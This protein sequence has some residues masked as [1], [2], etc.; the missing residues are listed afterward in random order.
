MNQ[1][2]ITLQQ[3]LVSPEV[4]GDRRV[5]FR[6]RAPQATAVKVT[7]VAGQ[8]PV[9][10]QRDSAGI[11]Q[12]TTAP[13]PPQRYSYLFE[14]D[15]AAQIDPYNRQVKKWLSLESMFEVPGE[16]PGDYEQTS[17]PHGVIH[18][19][20]YWSQAAGCERGVCVYTPPD[21]DLNRSPGYPT[22]YLLHGYG[23]DQ[24]TWTE[25]GRAH[26]VAD[27]LLACNQIESTVMVMPYGHPLPLELHT[28]FDHYTARN[29]MLMEQDL[30]QELMPLVRANYRTDADRGRQAIAGLSMG[31]WQALSIGLEHREQFA[32]IGGFSPAA[33]LGDL[34]VHLPRLAASAADAA[35]PVSLLWIGCGQEDFLLDRNHALIDWLQGRKLR[36]EFHRTPGGHDWIV[37]RN[38]LAEFLR[39]VFPART[40]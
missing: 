36:H 22:L 5:T 21:Y 40:P 1:M 15:G 23:D 24:T 7:G 11:W 38:Y 13:L 31:G 6:L 26:F 12:G 16:P 8:S 25:V 39:R 3:L 14:V 33:P 20:I 35:P 32:W 28:P 19:H 2:E 10:L 29:L 9:V 4:H 34:A 27:N 17:V 18:H 30:L 37:W